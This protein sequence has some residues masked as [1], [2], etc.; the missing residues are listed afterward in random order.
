MAQYGGSG[1]PGKVE[2]SR[3]DPGERAALAVDPRGQ[4]CRSC[5]SCRLLLC[6]CSSKIVHACPLSEGACGA[7]AVLLLSA[8]A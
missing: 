6:S 5:G 2:V 3:L 7:V 1:M 8:A 4:Q